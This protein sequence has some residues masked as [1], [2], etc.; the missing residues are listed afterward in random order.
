MLAALSPE[1]IAALDKVLGPP[2]EVRSGTDFVQRH[3]HPTHSTLLISGF[4]ARHVSL[5]DGGRQITEINVD[6]DFV[7]LHSLLMKQM[8]HGV[9]TLCPCVIAHAPHSRLATLWQL[10][11]GFFEAQADGLLQ[12]VGA[13]PQRQ[14]LV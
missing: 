5:A 11:A 1:E 7:D 10:A 9:V 3:G 13:V 4:A 2:R 12:R 14:T 6:G 8:D